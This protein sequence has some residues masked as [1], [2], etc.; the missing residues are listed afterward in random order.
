M[1]A[2][3]FRI[4]PTGQPYYETQGTGINWG[5]A[6]TNVARREGVS[7]HQV[8]YIGDVKEKKY[9][10]DYPTP[11]INSSAGMVGLIMGACVLYAFTPQILMIAGGAAGVWVAQKL[12]GQTMHEY[13]ERKDNR[14]HGSAAVIL[15]AAL[16]FGGVGFVQG[17]ALK[18]GFDA[19]SDSSSAPAEIESK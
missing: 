9:P 16:V 1:T 6:K 12:T 17:D 3:K 8:V 10:S 2:Y 4:M 14:G 19:P 5:V 15:A 18:K 13:N 7:D 11:E